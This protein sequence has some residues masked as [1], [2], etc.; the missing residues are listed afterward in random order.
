MLDRFVD[1][2]Y[3]RGNICVWLQY[4]VSVKEKTPSSGVSYLEVYCSGET[5]DA[6][7][8]VAMAGSGIVGSLSV[9]LQ[10]CQLWNWNG[11][12]LSPPW[13]CFQLS[14]HLKPDG[15]WS[16]SVPDK[17]M[18]CSD[19]ILKSKEGNNK[20]YLALTKINIFGLKKKFKDIKIFALWHFIYDN[21]AH[22][23]P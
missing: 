3:Y 5:K 23:P 21:L 6:F 8:H 9:P 16:G 14:V 7:C 18:H 2:W 1:L 17:N 11:G 15:V 13:P 10:G 20:W 22:L 12:G 4:N 19:F